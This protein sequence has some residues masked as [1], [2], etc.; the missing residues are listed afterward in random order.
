[1]GLAHLAIVSREN[2]RRLLGLVRHVD[3]VRAYNLALARRSEL[4]HRQKR[5]QLQHADGTEFVEI[6]LEEGDAAVGRRVREAAARMPFDFVL[7]SVQ[8]NG[9]TL[10]P[11]GDT[12]LQAGDL[13]TAFVRTDAVDDLNACLRS[14]PEPEDGMARR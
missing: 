5:M 3:A 4:A 12:R 6:R 14:A 1:R 10:I 11:H 13:I 7:V 2:P 8:R 9:T